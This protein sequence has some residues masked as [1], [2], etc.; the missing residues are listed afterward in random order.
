MYSVEV[1]RYQYVLSTDFILALAKQ[2]KILN[3]F[4]QLK[5]RTFRNA[6]IYER[7]FNCL[8]TIIMHIPIEPL[9][10]SYKKPGLIIC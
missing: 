4:C 1:S 2:I 3:D 8:N 10:S 5:N 7:K 9:Y 6:K